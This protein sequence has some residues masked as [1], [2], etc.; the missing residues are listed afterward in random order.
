MTAKK[1]KP[2]PKAMDFL[3]TST[4]VAR[5]NPALG[6][7]ALTTPEQWKRISSAVRASV[8]PFIALHPNGLRP[9]LS[10]MTRLAVWADLRGYEMSVDV[11]LAPDLVN[12]YVAQLALGAPDEEPYLWRLCRAWGLL[13]EGTVVRD[14]VARPDYQSPYSPADITALL[15]AS[16]AQNTQLREARLLAVIFL[17]GGC[18]ISRQSLRGVAAAAMHQ[19]GSEWFV[20]TSSRCAKVLPDYIDLFD[21]VRE[22]RPTGQLIGEV[23]RRDLTTHEVQWLK[24]R[25]GVPALSLDRLRATYIV[26]LLTSPNSLVDILEWTGLQG[27]EALNGYVAYLPRLKSTCPLA[28]SAQVPA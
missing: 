5:Y 28:K 6:D 19:H 8:Q 20:R 21:E 1:K 13:T 11:L 2:G 3:D 15:L 14:R 16:R 4:Y 23:E 9:Y 24:N 10:A 17:A 25:H 22:L 26:T 27:A 12:A 18:G 7:R